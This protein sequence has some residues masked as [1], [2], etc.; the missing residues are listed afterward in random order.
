MRGTRS[1]GDKLD[2]VVFDD[3]NVTFS[4]VLFCNQ[5]VLS[6]HYRQLERLGDRHNVKLVVQPGPYE[7]IE[8][9][10]QMGDRLGGDH[11]SIE[12]DVYWQAYRLQSPTPQKIID[13]FSQLQY[14]RLLAILDQDFERAK[15]LHERFGSYT[16][17][18]TAKA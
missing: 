7:V 9:L 11:L 16:K 15:R 10:Y 18:L 1:I 13:E 12:E 5:D 8:F 3:P 4:I 2:L 17:Y 6:K 14:E